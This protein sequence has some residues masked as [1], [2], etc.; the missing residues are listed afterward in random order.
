MNNKFIS[1]IDNMEVHT[2]LFLGSVELKLVMTKKYIKN[3]R[4]KS[5]GFNHW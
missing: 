3:R 5:H 1:H 2:L 4:A